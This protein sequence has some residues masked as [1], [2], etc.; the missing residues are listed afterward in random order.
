[1]ATLEDSP[2]ATGGPGIAPRWTHSAKDVVGTAYSTAEPRL[3]HGLRR[4][5]Q[6]GLLSDARPAANS[7][8]PVPGHRRRNLLSRRPPQSRST[9]EYLGEHGLGVRITNA[10]REGRYRIVKELIADPH[11]A[12]R[13]DRHASGRRPRFAATAPS[14]RPAGA[15]S[16]GRR[17]G[18]QRQRRADRRARVSH[19][20]QGRHLARARRHARPSCAAHAA[21]SAR[22][23]DGRTSPTTSRWTTSSPPPSDGNIALTGE[24]DLSR[25]TRVH[26]GTCLRPT[27]SI[28]R[29]RRCSSRSAF[30]SR[31]I[32]QRFIEQWERRLPH[33]LI[34][35][36]SS[37]A[38][39][40][41]SIARSHDLLLAH[42]DK[43]YPGAIIASLSIP[44]GEAKGDEDLGGY[45]LVWT[46][47][48]V[49]SATGL[50][51]AGDIATPLRA[52]IYLA[53]IAARR[54]RLSAEFLDRRASLLER[55]P[56]RRSRLP[57]HPGVAAARGRTRSAISIPI[58]WCARRRGYLIAH[59]PVTPQERWEENSGL[60]A[61]DPGQ[62]YRRADLRGRASPRERGDEATAA[63]ISRTTPISSKPMSR[64][65]RS[66]TNGTLVPGH[67][68]HYIRINPHGPRRSDA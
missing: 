35:W 19:R 42:E 48:M 34:R 53:C 2:V 50:L 33:M 25:G 40:A 29:S 51:A 22:P 20:A 9:T 8:P 3:V 16:R 45:H 27:A 62:Q 57:D 55:H 46:R 30:P 5:R 1:M 14:I 28:A 44:W 59:G 15:A 67:P 4:R 38:T 58:R 43:N 6:R 36:T 37:A 64:P 10:D 65:G 66:P 47:D 26:P 18:Q 68:R 13:A 60:F 32:A 41:R 11:Q 23:T 39:A 17:M 49:N 56:T 31:S 21:T 54:R 7:R 63:L 52:L 61:L 12:S 24:I